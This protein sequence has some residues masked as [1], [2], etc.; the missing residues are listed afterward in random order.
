MR[1]GY[2]TNSTIQFSSYI[3]QTANFGLANEAMNIGKQA[4]GLVKQVPGKVGQKAMNTLRGTG[5]AIGNAVGNPGANAF[6]YGDD[7][8]KAGQEGQSALKMAAGK[9][10]RK[11]GELV[12]GA[13]DWMQKNA[14]LTGGLALGAGA[15][16][17]GAGANAVINRNKKP[18]QPGMMY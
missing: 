10:I 5:T 2:R 1:K 15:L 8:L 14:A 18:Q 9:G 7:L 17:V 3:Y 11:T 6:V 13:G 4:W 12:S 16:G